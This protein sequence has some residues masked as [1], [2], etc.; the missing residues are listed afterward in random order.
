MAQFR[1]DQ[2]PTPRPGRNP[3]QPASWLRPAL[4]AGLGLYLVIVFFPFL[5][6]RGGPARVELSSSQPVSQIE[7]G[8]VTAIPIQGP[9]AQGA[10]ETPAPNNGGPNPRST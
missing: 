4:L 1:P 7:G 9:S 6:R 3:R 5:I 10:L 2:T 8:N